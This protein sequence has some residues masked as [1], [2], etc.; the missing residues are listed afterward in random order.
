VKPHVAAARAIGLALALVMTACGGSPARPSGTS[1]LATLMAPGRYSLSLVISSN[2]MEGLQPPCT[3]T[4]LPDLSG[5]LPLPITGFI[6]T[7]VSDSAG[8]LIVRPEAQ[9]DLGLELRL[10][11]SASGVSGTARGMA[12]DLMFPQTVLIDG[13]TPGSD[14]TFS[15]TF[16]FNHNDV[17]GPVSGRVVFDSGG[18][19][20]S[21]PFN[22]WIMNR[23]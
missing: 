19:T 21:C 16:G 5:T 14:A 17:G 11:A 20:Y 22:D 13:G 7:A 12:R 18:T 4:F 10:R 23:M 9:F 8:G 1:A 15:G 6:V 3:I 2:G